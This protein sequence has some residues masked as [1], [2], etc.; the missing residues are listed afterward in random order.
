LHSWPHPKSLSQ[1]R[2]TLKPD[3]DLFNNAFVLPI[4]LGRGGIREGEAEKKYLIDI[5][6]LIPDTH[7]KLL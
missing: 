7:I 6:L 2:G 4:F 3:C 5:L 1:E